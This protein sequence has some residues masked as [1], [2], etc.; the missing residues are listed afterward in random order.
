MGLAFLQPDD[1]NAVSE[2]FQ[3]GLILGH[4]IPFNKGFIIARE[5]YAKRKTRVGSPFDY[6]ERSSTISFQSQ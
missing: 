4:G 2:I 3:R 1:E 5:I 6:M